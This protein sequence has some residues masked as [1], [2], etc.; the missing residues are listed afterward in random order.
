MN[1]IEINDIYMKNYL[2]KYDKFGEYIY[3]LITQLMLEFSDLY[4]L[5]GCV[6]DMFIINKTPNDID[7]YCDINSYD[8]IINVIKLKL[9]KLYLKFYNKN[10][11]KIKL[12]KYTVDTA[13]NLIEST[14]I[15]VIGCF[16]KLLIDINVKS[17]YKLCT[18]VTSIHNNN[19]DF[20]Q[21]SLSL[22]LEKN[23][24]KNEIKLNTNIKFNKSTIKYLNKISPLTIIR[25]FICNIKISCNM[26]I[27]NKIYEFLGDEQ[28]R[29][30]Q[31][32]YTITQKEMYV[33]HTLCDKIPLKDH[34]YYD[35]EKCP[36]CINVF[37]NIY[38]RNKKY[39]TNGFKTY[40]KKCNMPLCVCSA[41]HDER[42]LL[43][44]SDKIIHD[45]AK[46]YNKNMTFNNY[47]KKKCA[48]GFYNNNLLFNYKIK[49][50]IDGI[51]PLNDILN[52]NKNYLYLNSSEYRKKQ[53]KN[54]KLCYL[55][56]L[57]NKLYNEL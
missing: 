16:G 22:S 35:G 45:Y 17:K 7:M 29:I 31:I 39:I 23:N 51:I 24:N 43:T 30:L 52:V 2:K 3:E 8:N 20:I 11:I 56:P 36:E 27:K 42:L 46:T 10:D 9:H 19:F 49:L 50:I 5:G 55:L 13:I 33:A 44:D 54:N 34:E 37:N 6:R 53:K 14:R 38:Y 41:I 26:L 32:I 12:K 21:N 28:I 15:E 48:T 18:C 4:I 40:V 1:N 25:K 57:Y 47:V